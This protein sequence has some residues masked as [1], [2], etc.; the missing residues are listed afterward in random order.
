MPTRRNWSLFAVAAV[1]AAIAVATTS[2]GH[3]LYSAP[4]AGSADNLVESQVDFN[5][6]ESQVEINFCAMDLQSLQLVPNVPVQLEVLGSNGD[7]GARQSGASGETGCTSWYG[8]PAYQTYRVTANYV[9]SNCPVLGT[10]PA[11][12]VYPGAEVDIGNL[13]LSCSSQQTLPMPSGEAECDVIQSIYQKT[14]SMYEKGEGID[15]PIY[16]TISGY[17]NRVVSSIALQYLYQNRTSNSPR[18]SAQIDYDGIKCK[19]TSTCRWNELKL[20]EDQPGTQK[21]CLV[22]MA[23]AKVDWYDFTKIGGNTGKWQ[24]LST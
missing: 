4:L 6:V 20:V 5:L 1:A 2:S 22:S 23:T 14:G 18:D 17:C 7:W 15:G 24:C 9:G 12:L 11:M 21:F 8:Q 3:G 13:M 16:I 19:N 10:T